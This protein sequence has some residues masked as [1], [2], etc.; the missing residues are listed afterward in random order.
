MA[1]CLQKTP[2]EAQ[3]VTMS[4]T[5]EVEVMSS[6]STPLPTIQ[7]RRPGRPRKMIPPEDTPIGGMV[8]GESGREAPEPAAMPSHIA[9]L[10][11]L[12][13]DRGMLDIGRHFQISPTGLL[14][15]GKPSFDTW[16]DFGELLRVFDRSLQLAVGDWLNYGEAMFGEQASQVIDAE[17]WSEAT[18][19]VYRWVAAKVPPQNRVALNHGLTFGHLRAVAALEPAAQKTWLDKAQAGDDGAQWSITQLQRA[20][21]ASGTAADMAPAAAKNEVHVTCESAAD[22]DAL[23][24]Q[25]ENLGRTAYVKIVDGKRVAS[26]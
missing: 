2:P 16:S 3:E 6:D 17:T 23:C 1:S 15:H 14:M 24:R 13:I 11:T 20:M 18:V 12:S 10:Q 5:S 21:K 7:R 19:R 4:T 26:V 25:L 22:V 8:L 9:E